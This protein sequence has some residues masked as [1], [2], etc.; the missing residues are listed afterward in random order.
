MN[1]RAQVSKTFR[2]QTEDFRPDKRRKLFICMNKHLPDILL[3]P[4][5]ELPFK[6]VILQVFMSL[7][8]KCNILSSCGLQIFFYLSP[9]TYKAIIKKSKILGGGQSFLFLKVS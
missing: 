7:I 2:D 8:N 9:D 5:I 1:F 6:S 3:F 4:F